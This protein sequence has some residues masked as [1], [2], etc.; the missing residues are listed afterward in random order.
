MVKPRNQA[1]TRPVHRGSRHHSHGSHNNLHNLVVSLSRRIFLQRAR[2]S[3]WERVSSQVQ[4]E[5][6]KGE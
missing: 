2:Q 4:E 3:A 1:Q 6:R 5:P